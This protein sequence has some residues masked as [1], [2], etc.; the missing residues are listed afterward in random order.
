MTSPTTSG[1]KVEIGR[2]ESRK[3]KIDEND[4]D[5]HALKIRH[6]EVMTNYYE[7]KTALID[8]QLKEIMQKSEHNK[9][10]AFIESATSSDSE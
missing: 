9:R 2:K 3:R 10:K 5:Y 6:L 4:P 1:L 8:F 7:K